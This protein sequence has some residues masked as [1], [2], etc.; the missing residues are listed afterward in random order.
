MQIAIL[1]RQPEISLAELESLFGAEN[2]TPLGK[3][4]ALGT[5]KTHS[6]KL[7]LVAQ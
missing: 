2:V 7:A 1:G 5:A 4:A 3:Y 6:P